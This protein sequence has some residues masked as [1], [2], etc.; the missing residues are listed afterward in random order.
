MRAQHS[1]KILAWELSFSCGLILTK[2]A[3][4]LP[5]NEVRTN[6]NSKWITL[7]VKKKKK[8][9]CDNFFFVGSTFR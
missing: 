8:K 1:I 6:L 2:D 9:I 5:D 4:P 7:E 3:H